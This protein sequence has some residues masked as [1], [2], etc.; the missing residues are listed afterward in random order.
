MLRIFFLALPFTQ[1]RIK[2]HTYF[3]DVILFTLTKL[4]IAQGILSGFQLLLQKAQ[5]SHRR[6]Q[7]CQLHVGVLLTLQQS[8]GKRHSGLD[9]AQD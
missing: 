5:I 9:L 4:F 6:K 7:I 8:N 2:F 1:D 3:G